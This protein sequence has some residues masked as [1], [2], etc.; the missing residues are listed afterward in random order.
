[1]QQIAIREASGLPGRH[2]AVPGKDGLDQLTVTQTHR[3]IRS[4]PACSHRIST[5][6]RVLFVRDRGP[7]R[8]RS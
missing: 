1:M 2:D 7:G 3:V 5:V 4:G 6:D 8:G